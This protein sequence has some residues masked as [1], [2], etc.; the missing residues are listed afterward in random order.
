MSA[1]VLPYFGDQ[2]M[3][4]KPPAP[5][6]IKHNYAAGVDLSTDPRVVVPCID[7]NDGSYLVL[8]N[9]GTN[10]STLV[11]RYNASNVLT[12]QLD[13]WMFTENPSQNHPIRCGICY[14]ATSNRYYVPYSKY[15]PHMG[16][17]LA[18]VIY[19]T[20]STT[21]AYTRKGPN[22]SAGFPPFDGTAVTDMQTSMRDA[23]YL[24]IIYNGYEIFFNV[25]TGFFAIISPLSNN[26]IT[27]PFRINYRTADWTIFCSSVYMMPSGIAV[28]DIIRNG[29]QIKVPINW[30]KPSILTAGAEHNS[31][32]PIILGDYIYFAEYSKQFAS[33]IKTIK[34]T[35]FDS[36]LKRMCDAMG[37]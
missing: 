4:V 37:I 19:I 31:V 13:F 33:G 20:N 25:S 3:G 34:R 1:P 11:G 32:S 27:L 2:F 23:A 6:A 28:M 21:G 10:G 29:Y 7:V 14:D 17:Y 15:N 5:A 9:T 16:G 18:E 22:S 35:E 12:W 36:W 8:R 30:V 24:S 26:G